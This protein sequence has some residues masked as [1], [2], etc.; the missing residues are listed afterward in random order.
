MAF[1]VH[2]NFK[3]KAARTAMTGYAR[4]QR[5]S[6]VREQNIEI[7]KYLSLYNK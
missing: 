7:G 1:V 4:A 3:E 6:G 2:R 5:L